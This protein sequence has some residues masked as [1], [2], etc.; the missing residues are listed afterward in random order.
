M[1]VQV[2]THRTDTERFRPTGVLFTWWIMEGVSDRCWRFV[3]SQR[4]RGVLVDLGG[5]YVEN[6]RRM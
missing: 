3:R 6:T 4:I 2:D 1:T 5:R